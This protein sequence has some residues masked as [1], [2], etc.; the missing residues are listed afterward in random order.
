MQLW[1]VGVLGITWK[2]QEKGYILQG[3]SFENIDQ[4]WNPTGNQPQV[5][6]SVSAIYLSLVMGTTGL[7][8]LVTVIILHLHHKPHDSPVPRWLCRILC[9]NFNDRRG[10]Q[11]RETTEIMD[12][13]VKL[14][15]TESSLSNGQ[16]SLSNGTVRQSNGQQ[17]WKDSRPDHLPKYDKKYDKKYDMKELESKWKMATRR[18][19]QSCFVLF[20]I[21]FVILTLIMVYPYYKASSLNNLRCEKSIIGSMWYWAIL[22]F[23]FLVC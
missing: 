3:N 19:D 5:L 8:L 11:R 18:I 21:I 2:T 4:F 14:E 9:L 10:L 7:S 12:N 23:P 13:G 1:T 6:L 15:K 22:V 16:A 17:N 20:S